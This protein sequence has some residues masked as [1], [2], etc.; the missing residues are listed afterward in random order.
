MPPGGVRRRYRVKLEGVPDRDLS[1]SDGRRGHDAE[2][3]EA[4]A[5]EDEELID[6]GGQRTVRGFDRL[7]EVLVSSTTSAPLT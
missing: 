7:A 4:R 1:A 6:V 3:A 5:A 2:E